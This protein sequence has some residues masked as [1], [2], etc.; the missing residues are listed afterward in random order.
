MCDDV[1][2]TV[3]ELQAKGVD[4][5]R[6]V[7][8]E[9]FGLMTAIRLPGASARLRVAGHGRSWTSVSRGGG[10]PPSPRPRRPVG[11]WTRLEARKRTLDSI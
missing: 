5:A 7:S 6:R 3:A 11:T 4:F 9:G 10:R 1:H 2:A 8:D